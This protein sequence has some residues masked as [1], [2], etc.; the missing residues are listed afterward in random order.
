MR[1]RS[2]LAVSGVDRQIGFNT[3]TTL[4]MV[5]SPTGFSVAMPRA[6]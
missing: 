4:S 2:L 6:F 5:I 3:A 1:P